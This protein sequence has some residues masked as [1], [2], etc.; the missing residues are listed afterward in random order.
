[1]SVTLDDG[2][3]AECALKG[4]SETIDFARLDAGGAHVQPLR[5]TPHP[6]TDSLDVRVPAAAGT[7]VRVRDTVPEP[8]S[9]AADVTD[10]SHGNSIHAPGPAVLARTSMPRERSAGQAGRRGTPTVEAY[11]KTGQDPTPGIHVSGRAPDH[12]PEGRIRLRK[13]PAEEP[14]QDTTLPQV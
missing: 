7:A 12:Q 2:A 1:S 11:P 3:H 5:R 8:R 10:G 4:H 9:L 13:S 6:G 14:S